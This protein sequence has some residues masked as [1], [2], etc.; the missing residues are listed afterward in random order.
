MSKLDNNKKRIIH[1]GL[2]SKV[3]KEIISSVIGSLS[4]GWGENNPANEKWWRFADCVQAPDGEVLIEVSTESWEYDEFRSYS[5]KYTYNGF[6]SMSDVEVMQKFAGW[7]KKTAKMEMNDENA[8]N[9]WNRGSE[10]KLDYLN[11]HENVTAADAYFVYETLLGR[12]NTRKYSCSTV[13]KVLGKKLS[14]EAIKA[15]EEKA[16]EIAEKLAY[17]D[18]LLKQLKEK[19]DADIKQIEAQY[20][21]DWHDICD[22]YKKLIDGIK[23]A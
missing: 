22:Q 10:M 15:N 1:T 14:D 11:Y 12:D 19:K 5:H 20:A 4:D 7:I 17:R 8:G 6:H 2:Y 18:Q 13:Q 16:K 21:K 23:A 9:Q 3:A